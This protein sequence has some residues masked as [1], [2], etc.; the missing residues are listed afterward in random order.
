MVIGIVQKDRD[1]VNGILGTGI[2]YSVHLMIRKAAKINDFSNPCINV[3]IIR[4]HGQ[5][6][7][8]SIVN[9]IRYI[10]FSSKG[11][12]FYEWFIMHDLLRKW[13]WIHF[14]VANRDKL[15]AIHTTDRVFSRQPFLKTH[16]Y[17]NS[18]SG[19]ILTSFS[20]LETT[21]S[22]PPKT[23]NSTP[24]PLFSNLSHLYESTDGVSWQ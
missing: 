12:Y 6:N 22:P 9:F 2:C 16:Q 13:N 14:L 3:G 7:Y 11:W 4:E 19:F 20:E 10:F 1:S 15:I 18:L 17:V 24:P 8:T 23:E 5:N 21:S